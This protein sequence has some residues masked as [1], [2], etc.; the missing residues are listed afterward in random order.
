VATLTAPTLLT[1]STR[2]LSPRLLGAFDPVLLGWC[3]RESL[4]GE[5]QQPVTINGVFRPFALVDGRAVAVWSIVSGKVTLKPFAPIDTDV[6]RKLQAD[7]EKVLRY[8]G[9]ARPTSGSGKR[10]GATPV[11]WWARSCHRAARW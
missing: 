6:E 4:V 11:C 5:N 1:A 10:A 3:S 9:L 7:G 8:L 2:R